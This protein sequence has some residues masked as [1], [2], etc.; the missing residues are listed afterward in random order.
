MNYWKSVVS[1]SKHDIAIIRL[2][3]LYPFPEHELK[4]ALRT[5]CS[6]KKYGLVSGRTE[7]PG[8]MVYH[9][10]SFLTAYLNNAELELCRPRI[11]GCAFWWL[12]RVTQKTTSCT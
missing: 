3:Q 6:G 4:Q 11:H 12:F 8:R 5:L 2:E 9:V 7:K 10:R 1:K